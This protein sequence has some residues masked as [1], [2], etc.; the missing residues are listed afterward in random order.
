MKNFGKPGGFGGGRGGGG[1]RGGGRPSFGSRG[2]YGGGRE[3][4]QLFDAQCATCGRECQVPFEP[5]G[6]K[7]VYCKDHFVR[8]EEGERSYDRPRRDERPSFTPA[9]AAKA[10]PDPRI[11]AL[12]R[13][14]ESLTLKV[15]TVIG[16]LRKEALSETIKKV[17]KV[18]KEPKKKAVKK[19]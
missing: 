17:T 5:N 2:G 12:K 13:D 6:K 4:R 10:Q 15:D 9:P 11:D 18:T 19:Q 14:I 8:S 16:L 1:F 7:P 3:E